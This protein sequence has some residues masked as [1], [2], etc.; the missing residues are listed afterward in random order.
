M[1]EEF[2]DPCFRDDVQA[3]ATTLCTDCKEFLC[4]DCV[5]AHRRKKLSLAHVLLDVK[6]IGSLPQSTVSSHIFCDIHQAT[7][8]DFYC[9]LL[10]I[11]IRFSISSDNL[12]MIGS[13][14]MFLDASLRGITLSQVRCTS[15]M[16]ER[17]H[18]FSSRG[19]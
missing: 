11:L 10:E 4:D 6:Q 8:L 14:L 12:S 9:P 16:H 19:Q 18:V 2:L 5:R 1:A 13:D 17:Q 7:T 3:K 15:T